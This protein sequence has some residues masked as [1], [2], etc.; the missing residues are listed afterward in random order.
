M[1]SPLRGCALFACALTVMLFGGATA[2]A[3]VSTDPGLRV[4]V[5]PSPAAPGSV[6]TITATAT[7]GTGPESASLEVRC[8]LSW[9]GRGNSVTLNPDATGLVFTIDATVPLAS[10]PGLRVGT[11]TVS[12]EQ[13]REATV[14]YTFTIGEVA[15][16]APPSVS[17]GGPYSGAEGGTVSLAANGSD[18]EGGTL[19][20]AW[21]LDNDGTYETTGMTPT[22][23]A[24][25]LDGPSSYTVGV[26]VTDDG[27]LTAVATA[28]VDVT[29]VAPT[30][31]LESPATASVGLAF[32]LALVSAE[33]VSAADAAA[34]F[35]YAFD[36]GNGYGPFG[37]ASSGQ[38]APTRPGTLSVGGKIRDKDG[39]IA[40]YRSTVHVRLTSAGLCALVRA[41]S[42]E[43]KVAADLC[44]KLARADLATTPEARAGV[45][46]AFRNQASAKIGK[47]LTAEQVAELDRLSRLL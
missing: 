14:G 41:Y 24:A 18:P 15:A 27:G 29:N 25:A 20:Y 19:S 10:V 7:P 5:A 26:Q 1:N 43:P 2:A 35:T 9:A 44:A 30:A 39:G 4:D 47:G 8:D 37:A 45:L 34:G 42:T 13:F 33:D 6:V 16:N 28:T 23:S 17:A 11:C 12:D 38:C 31:T 36:C 32:P 46:E 21:D 3:D 40:E 22:F